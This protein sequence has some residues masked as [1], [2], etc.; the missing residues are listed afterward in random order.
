MVVTFGSQSI[1]TSYVTLYIVLLCV[2]KWPARYSFKKKL[3][4]I[5]PQS[6]GRIKNSQPEPQ[7]YWFLQESVIFG[8]SLLRADWQK[9]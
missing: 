2:S 4:T 3:R 7:F 6:M 5:Q 1:K 9:G 8:A